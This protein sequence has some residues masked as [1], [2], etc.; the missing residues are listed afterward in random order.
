MKV[1]LPKPLE[2]VERGFVLVPNSVY[3]VRIIAVVKK[4][5]PQE[6]YLQWSLVVFDHPEWDGAV[7]PYVTPIAVQSLWKLV[8]L[9]VACGVE[10][11]GKE[12]DTDLLMD[13]DLWVTTTQEEY[14]K[15]SGTFRTKV[16][17]CH[18]ADP[19]GEGE[20]SDMEASDDSRAIAEAEDDLPF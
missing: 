15:N 12:L 16:S 13:R 6:I 19:R 9:E 17:A 7:I 10:P 3:H 1:P 4:K 18:K 11:S 5:G 14:P 2:E 8:N 20:S